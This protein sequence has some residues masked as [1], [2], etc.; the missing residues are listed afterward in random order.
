MQSAQSI[1]IDLPVK[2]PAWEDG[3]GQVWL[4][5]NVAA[6]LAARHGV[7]DRAE[8]VKAM[9]NTLEALSAAATRGS[10]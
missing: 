4:G 7:S 10:R 8:V 6:W 1:G 2:M 3:Q 5:Y 9:T